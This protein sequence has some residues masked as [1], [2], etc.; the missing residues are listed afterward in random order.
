M[1]GPRF[2]A[3]AG[4]PRRRC[5][6]WTLTASTTARSGQTHILAPPAP[7]ILEALAGNAGDADDILQRIGDRFD[8]AGGRRGGRDRR[9]PGRT[10][11]GGA[12]A[13]AM[14]H[15][16]AC[17]SGRWRSASARNGGG[18]STQ[19]RRLYAGYPEP[20]GVCDFT[21]RLEP[22]TAVAPL[23]PPLGGDHAAT[24]S[25]PTPRLCRSR[26]ACSPPRWG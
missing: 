11:G 23:H 21:V 26:S 1:A 3:D 13:A 14:R 22:E 5:S 12:G 6:S 4:G 7:Q 2:I 18:R 20:E 15:R 8:V 10:G 9:A 17:R 19:L 16:L 25:C 24:T